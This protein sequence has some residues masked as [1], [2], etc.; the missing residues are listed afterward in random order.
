MSNYNSL[1]STIDAN[2]KQNGNQEITGQILNSVLNQMVTTLGAGYQ[3]AGVATLDPAT[4]PGTPDA[5]VFYI[6]NGKGTYTNFGGVNVTEDDVVVLYWDSS[7]HKVSTGIASNAKLTELVS[8]VEVYSASDVSLRKCFIDNNNNTLTYTDNDTYRVSAIMKVYSPKLRI[9]GVTSFGAS[10]QYAKF[11]ADMNFLGVFKP[12]SAGTHLATEVF[13]YTLD[14]SVKY[15]QASLHENDINTLSIVCDDALMFEVADDKVRAEQKTTANVYNGILSEEGKFIANNDSA[16][17]LTKNDTYC[18]SDFIKV[19]S[20]RIDISGVTN[21][22]GSPRY[23]KFDAGRNFLG[24]FQPISSG[25]HQVN[26]HF[27]YEFYDETAYI[28]ASIHINDI[29]TLKVVSDGVP[30]FYPNDITLEKKINSLT[31]VEKALS[32]PLFSLIE[33]N[34]K[35]SRLDFSSVGVYDYYAAFDELAY[36]FKRNFTK[37]TDIGRSTTPEGSWATKDSNTYPICHYQFKKA[38][39]N[40]TRRI[41][42]CGANHG[43][44]EDLTGDWYNNGGDSPQNILTQLF[45][46]YD[47]L[48]NPEKY[49]FFYDNFIIDV[50]PILNPWGVQ[51]HSRGNGRGVDLNRNYD[52]NW[53]GGTTY[54]GLTIGQ[55]AFSEDESLA[56]KNFFESVSGVELCLEIHAR[57]DILIPSN[58]QF[59]SAVDDS[60][61]SAKVAAIVRTKITSRFAGS[62]NSQIVTAAS[63]ANWVYAVKGVDAFEPECAQTLNNDIHTRNSKVVNYQMTEFVIALLTGWFE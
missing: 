18:V 1:K 30:L 6:A 25:V 48:M 20:K 46:L 35:G 31:K 26:E 12:I 50:I 13:V 2:I 57:G 24:V 44:S 62:L 32:V 11:D 10:P 15:I 5:K 21:F 23:A 34:S 40:P 45:F 29:E 19:F 54:E 61:L 42:L 14:S 17:T 39:T 16:F 63:L 47:L 27:A 55:S 7:W 53:E 51:N 9:K 56:F 28:K 8:D 22:G 52:Y 41:I 43:D 37:L 33:R 60:T 59:L 49:Q 58:V 36:T 4:D 38:G 3:F